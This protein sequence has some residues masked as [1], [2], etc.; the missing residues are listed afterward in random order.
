MLIPEQAGLDGSHDVS[1]GAPLYVG[2]L[3]P[4]PYIGRGK[5]RRVRAGFASCFSCHVTKNDYMLSFI[6]RLLKK[7]G[8]NTRRCHVPPVGGT[9]LGR[10]TGDV[11][12]ALTM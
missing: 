11:A 5:T 1:L 8:E 12:V 3:E 10:M 9:S 4:L 2:R 6:S 7:H